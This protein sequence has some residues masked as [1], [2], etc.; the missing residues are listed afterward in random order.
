MEIVV[1]GIIMRNTE[2]HPNYYVSEDGEH[3]YSKMKK[4][5]YF[6][7]L[8]SDRGYRKIN[9]LDGRRNVG[10][11]LYVWQAWKG[12]IPKGYE[13][14]HID[15]CPSNNNLSNLMCLTK[16]EHLALHLVNLKSIRRRHIARLGR[17][18]W[19]KGKKHS[20]E[21][22]EKMKQ[23]AK[24]RLRDKNTGQFIQNI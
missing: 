3:V 12:P 6:M 9:Y 22:I 19:N 5:G 24:L 10:V 11:H 17:A 16:K 2:K 8:K 13:I 20:K 18:S 15:N 4:T 14:H 21:T 1:S 23:K 7:N